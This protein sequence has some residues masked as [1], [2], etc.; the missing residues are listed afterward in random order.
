MLMDDVKNRLR[1]LNYSIR[2][3]T[4]YLYWIKRFIVHQDKKHPNEMG[5]QEV[6]GFLTYLAVKSNV[7]ATTQNQALSAIL[8]LYKEVLKMDL[9]WVKGIKRAKKPAKLPVVFSVNEMKSIISHMTGEHL[10]ASRLL[11]GSGLRLM[12]CIRLRITDIDFEYKRVCVR[13]GKGD[14]DRYTI[15]PD[16]V[17]PF[18]QDQIERVQNIH[19]QDLAKG[20]GKVYLPNSLSKKYPNANKELAW[21]YVFPSSKLSVDPRSGI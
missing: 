13:R 6:E 2:T 11:Y 17:I 19:E 14:K 9:D 20:F 16:S 5:S 1:R 12:E 18:L 3:E 7:A 8:F 4:A 21:Q 15:L 10:L